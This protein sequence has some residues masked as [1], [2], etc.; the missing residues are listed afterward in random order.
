MRIQVLFFGMST[1]FFAPTVTFGVTKTVEFSGTCVSDCAQVPCTTFVVQITDVTVVQGGGS[2]VPGTRVAVNKQ[3][4]CSWSGVKTQIDF[5]SMMNAADKIKVTLKSRGCAVVDGTLIVCE[6]T[7]TIDIDGTKTM[8][9]GIQMV[10]ETQV[11][12]GNDK[13]V[14]GTLDS[15]DNCPTDFNPDQENIDNDAM[16][17]ACDPC[18]KDSDNT[19]VPD[20]PI[21]GA[22]CL[23]DGGCITTEPEECIDIQDA[24][25]LGDG[26]VCKAP[27]P[28]VDV[29]VG[30]LLGDNTNPA[31]ISANDMNFDGVVD[32]KDIESYMELLLGQSSQ[33]DDCTN[34]KP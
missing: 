4:D 1:A 26:T 28:D 9:T 16:G 24:T 25:Y 2:E 18:P 11:S 30:M 10:K 22:C 15:C 12:P 14:D 3:M 27:I 19:C 13:D 21:V 29:F 20:A 17:D 33:N 7:K 5:G 8:W 32:G 6:D 23:A 34:V 31:D